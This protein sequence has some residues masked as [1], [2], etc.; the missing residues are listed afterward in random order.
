MNMLRRTSDLQPDEAVLR[1][2]IQALNHTSDF[3]LLTQQ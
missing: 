3:I 2:L 1:L